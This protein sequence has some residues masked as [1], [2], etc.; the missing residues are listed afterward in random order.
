ML[1]LTGISN[2]V[3]DT[4]QHMT[5]AINR[6]FVLFVLYFPVCQTH[7]KYFLTKTLQDIDLYLIAISGGAFLILK[8]NHF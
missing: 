1:I 7:G 8:N 2:L 4:I 6:R 5:S 3:R